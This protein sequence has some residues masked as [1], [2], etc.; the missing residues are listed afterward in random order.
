MIY[1]LSELT[2][3]SPEIGFRVV[4]TR[5]I[6]MGTVTWVFDGLDQIVSPPRAAELSLRLQ[7]PLDICDYQNSRGEHILCWDYARITSG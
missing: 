5:F 4:A 6:P 3:V 1:P 2:F 7:R